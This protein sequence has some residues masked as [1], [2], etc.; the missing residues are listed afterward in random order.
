V[1]VK[2]IVLMATLVSFGSLAAAPERVAGSKIGLTLHQTQD[3]VEVVLS[4]PG[5]LQDYSCRFHGEPDRQVIIDL[6]ED[7]ADL[8]DRY[9]GL[10][11]LVREILVDKKTEGSG[12]IIHVMLGEGDVSGFDAAEGVLRLRL[13]PVRAIQPELL[14]EGYRVGTGDKLEISV[15]GHEDLNKIVEVRAD[16]TVKFPLVG[17]FHVAGK[18]PSEIDDEL[19]ALL[20][21][22]YLVD[23]QVNVDVK[24][25]QSQAVTILGEVRSP[26]RYFL[27]RNMRMIDLLADA[28]GATKDAGPEIIVTR[29]SSEPSGRQV[30]IR[31]DALFSRNNVEANIPLHS[32]DIVTIAERQ[33]FYIKGEVVRPGS[34]FIETGMSLLKALSIAGGLTQFANRREIEILRSKPGN[35]GQEKIVINIKDVESGKREDIPLFPDDLINVPRRIF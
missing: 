24:E 19:T 20:A 3:G 26:G 35:R 32:G 16:G 13:E 6:P 28:G 15:F 1:D 14:E 18:S 5:G 7:A 21:K 27:K 31:L 34:Y 25:Y 30:V 8:A 11:P 9:E 23:P 12:A 10:P 22:D 33:A 29:H 17:D 4:A 2:R